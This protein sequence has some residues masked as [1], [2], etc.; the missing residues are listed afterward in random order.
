MT[1]AL[2]KGAA[3]PPEEP[4]PDSK[5]ESKVLGA[6][7]LNPAFSCGL[8]S[9]TFGAPAFASWR[10]IGAANVADALEE[11]IEAVRGGD[12]SGLEALLVAQAF[13]LQAVFVDCSTRARGQSSRE[14]SG[15]L[16]QVALKAQGQCRATVQTIGELKAPRST[17]F[18]RQAN[19]TTGGNQQV[20]NGVDPVGATRAR[21]EVRPMPNKLIEAERAHGGTILDAGAAPAASRADRE[22]ETLEVG[23]RPAQRRGKSCGRA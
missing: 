22:L 4:T 5:L 7:L 9:S 6:M 21:E 1:K 10:K 18:A 12:M 15:T 3:P 8:V 19:I 11:T 20:N 16:M 17:V 14:A 2:R 23:H 13:A